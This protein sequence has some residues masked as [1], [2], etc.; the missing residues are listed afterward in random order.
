VGA[1]GQLACSFPT[2]CPEMP[3]GFLAGCCQGDGGGWPCLFLDLKANLLTLPV[4]DCWLW[5][6][7]RMEGLSLC[8][9]S[10]LQ[11]ED[12]EEPYL[13]HKPAGED[14]P[15]DPHQPQALWPVLL[16]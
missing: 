16:L 1:R 14:R 8:L 3:T 9:S 2:P 10:A 11:K 4:T 6:S 15:T 13:L 7:A 12:R 5:C